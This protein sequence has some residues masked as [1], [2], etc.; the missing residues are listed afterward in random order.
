MDE[1]G[2]IRVKSKFQNLRAPF[3]QKFSILLHKDCPFTHCIVNSYHLKL[4][5]AGVYRLLSSLRKEFWIPSAF[6]TVKKCIGKCLICKKIFG[7]TVKLN[8]N[9]YKDYRINPVK[10]PYREVVPNHIGPFIIKNDHGENV[11][12]YILIITCMWS[13]AVNLLLCRNIDKECFLQA[14]QIHIF[15][16][17][18]PQRIISDNGSPIVGS[19]P[20]MKEFLN[21]T[22]VINF[23]KER[24]IKLLNFQP[25]P[26]NASFLGGLVESLVK[27]VKNMIYSSIGR[28]VLTYDHFYFLV[29]E[30]NM[31]VNKRPI[32]YKAT[33]VNQE[34]DPSV[35]VITPEMLVRGYEVPCIAVIP[36]LEI[37]DIP[38]GDECWSEGRGNPDL[39]AK[40]EN[41]CKVKTRLNKIYYDEFL[42]TLREMD[43]NRSDKY[44]VRNHTA[45]E[46]NDL[47][48]LMERFANLTS[49]LPVL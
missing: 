45:L 33:L 1:D 8:H 7:R 10:I 40:F 16:N 22:E 34:T 4:K 31:L 12:A 49:I 26:A 18:M 17:G 15:E 25:Y 30:V 13:R 11:K 29:K 28:N 44:K 42:K 37:K 5:H 23:L 39:F 27:Q 20:Q 19:I 14:I 48:A 3:V 32:A 43:T 2:V 38:Q 47:V 36:Q 9:A 46:V 35:S 21:D 6:S 24:N 41:L